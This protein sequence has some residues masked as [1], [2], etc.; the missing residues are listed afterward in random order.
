MGIGAHTTVHTEP[1]PHPVVL[2]WATSGCPDH[3][4][5]V[6]V[7][8][9]C[10]FPQHHPNPGLLVNGCSPCTPLPL[11]HPGEGQ[12]LGQGFPVQLCT[13]RSPRKGRTGAVQ[14]SPL[15]PSNLGENREVEP[16]AQAHTAGTWC[17]GTLSPGMDPSW[18]DVSIFR[19]GSEAMDIRC[20]T[21][22]QVLFLYSH[23]R[24]PSGIY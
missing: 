21:S 20:Q 15:V 10:H 7:C 23:A 1:A 17:G 6:V 18:A 19:K 2:L 5:E 9:H 4:V 24:T 11:L 22:A 3:T 12:A 14:W 16:L 13:L 8:C